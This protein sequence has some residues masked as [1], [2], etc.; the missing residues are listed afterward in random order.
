MEI[1]KEENKKAAAASADPSL[2][3]LF[4][5]VMCTCEQKSLTEKKKA[6]RGGGE[7]ISCNAVSGQTTWPHRY[8]VAVFYS[9]RIHKTAQHHNRITLTID[10]QIRCISCFFS[11]SLVLSFLVGNCAHHFSSNEKRDGKKSH[12]RKIWLRSLQ[13]TSVHKIRYACEWLGVIMKMIQWIFYRV[14]TVYW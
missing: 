8:G 10:A 5:F 9:Q 3:S 12:C 7:C 11:S 14:T 13:H 6:S 1:K 4:I 2:K